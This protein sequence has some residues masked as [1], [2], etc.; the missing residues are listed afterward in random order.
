MLSV[1]VLGTNGLYPTQNSN[2]SGYLVKGDNQAIL[3]DVGSGVFKELFNHLNPKDLTAIYISHLHHDHVSDLG[4]FN[5]YL[6]S[7]AKKGEFTGKIKVLVKSDESAVY[8][9]I[10]QLNYF[11]LCDFSVN[12]SKNIGNFVF[13]FYK[14]NHPVQTHGVVV[15][16]NDKSIG[17]LAD[18]NICE[19]IENIISASDLTI[20]HTP[21]LFDKWKENLAHVCPKIVSEIAKKHNKRIILSHFLPTSN[22]S[23][24]LAEALSVWQKVE[25]AIT[26]K[27]YKA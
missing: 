6:E 12:E 20:C 22:A 9:A 18:S 25:Q 19:S 27:E 11:E 17:Y 2:T 5:Y 23:E 8:R 16:Y 21:F 1:T 14:M 4:V 15:K 3:L 26:N 13:N 10:E 7:L 24:E